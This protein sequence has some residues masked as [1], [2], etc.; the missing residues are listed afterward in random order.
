MNIVP[1]DAARA[2]QR[3][4]M[5]LAPD[6]LASYHSRCPELNFLSSDSDS[7]FS[8]YNEVLVIVRSG[9]NDLLT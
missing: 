8:A 3:F 7:G 5:S 4:A 6:S 9:R 2:T 1:R